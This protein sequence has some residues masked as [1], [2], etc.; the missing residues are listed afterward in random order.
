MGID[1]SNPVLPYCVITSGMLRIVGER[2]RT[3]AKLELAYT[4]MQL[5]AIAKT[6]PHAANAAFVHG[7]G[8][9]LPG[10]FLILKRSCNP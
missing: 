9:T 10:L 7:S 1:Y 5:S 6:Q 8:H 3:S 4:V 2:A